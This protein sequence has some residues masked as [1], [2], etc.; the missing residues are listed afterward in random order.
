MYT[1]VLEDIK[2]GIYKIGKTTVPID[3]FKS[4][5]LR[6][7]VMPLALA[8]KDIEKDLH[9]QFAD[10]RTVHPDYTKNGETEWFKKGGKIDAFIKKVRKDH[11]LPYITV[12]YMVIDLLENATIRT[13]DA[14]TEW[15]LNQSSFG[16][17]LIGLK[18]LKLL[19]VIKEEGKI[20]TTKH[21]KHVLII[22][23]KVA[24]SDALIERIKD[25]YEITL[26]VECPPRKEQV[27][28]G[29]TVRKITIESASFDSD[30]YM[31]M[32]KL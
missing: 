4:L 29:V 18:I 24:V 2:L 21:S 16:H 15:E 27:G 30:I 11:H 17:Y 6:G 31:L 20:Y 7:R 23:K 13:R 26:S 5:C 25:K 12:H 32:K 14:S 8:G 1:Y 3:R 22:G 10:N 19:G 9:E 28:K